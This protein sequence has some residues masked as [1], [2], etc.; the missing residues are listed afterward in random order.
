MLKPNANNKHMINRNTPITLIVLVMLAVMSCKEPEGIGLDVLPSG[1][2]MAIAWV[3]SFTIKAQ[4]VKTDS[5]F[6]S[7]LNTYLI[8]DFGDPVFGRVKSELYTQIRLPSGTFTPG[9]ATIDSI[10]LNLA[11][12]GSYGNTTKLGGTMRFGVYKLQEFLPS[13]SDTVYFSTSTHPVDPN[14]LAEHTFRPDLFSQVIAGEDTLPPSLRIRL[15]NALGQEILNLSNEQLSD[16]SE[17]VKAI[18]G[19]AVKPIDAFMPEGFGSIL[20]FNLGSSASRVEV[21]YHNNDQDSLRINLDV[22]NSG[23]PHM[24]FEHEYSN[25]IETAVNDSIVAGATKLYIQS[26]AGLKIKLQVPNLRALNEQGVVSVNKAEL[27]VPVDETFITDYSIPSRL[28]MTGID[29]IGR[30]ITTNDNEENYSIEEG[31]YDS[32]KKEYV[33]IVTRHIQEILSKPEEEDLGMYILGTGF[34]VN[35]KRGV[36]NGPQHPDKPMKLR[37]TYTIIED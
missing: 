5:V 18:N 23:A 13:L 9:T 21:Y 22:S 28:A 30:E 6:T 14:P 31:Y 10:V 7:G 8:G 26:M 25:E 17:F 16:N 3:D 24:Y 37:M 11:Y 4:T 32:E 20:Y 12:A 2:E 35:A 1:E 15:D 19:I 33:L 34:S 27:V 29:T 36:F